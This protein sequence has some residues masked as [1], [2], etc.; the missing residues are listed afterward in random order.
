MWACLY[1]QARREGEDPNGQPCWPH[2]PLEPKG[3]L[4]AD[5]THRPIGTSES[6]SSRVPNAPAASLW[7]VSLGPAAF[8]AACSRSS[9]QLQTQALIEFP[10]PCLPSSPRG[11][12]DL[13]SEPHS[14]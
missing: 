8:I 14:A 11:A 6:C 9:P 12:I 7:P 3:V 13:R 1:L 2:A 5:L 10:Q 4:M